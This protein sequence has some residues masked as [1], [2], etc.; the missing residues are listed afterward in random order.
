[1]SSEHLSDIWR[2]LPRTQTSLFWWKCARKGR[3]EGDNGRDASPAVCTLPMVP[4]GLLWSPVT[5]FALS[6]AMWKT[7]RLRRRLWRSTFEISVGAASFRY[8]NH[9]S[10]VWIEALSSMVFDSAQKQSDIGWT[11]PKSKVGRSSSKLI[12]GCSLWVIRVYLVL[13]LVKFSR[14][15][16]SPFKVINVWHQLSPKRKAKLFFSQ[17]S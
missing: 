15:G 4:C 13:A 1:M 2:S 16:R 3:R 6:S 10:Y 8:R 5:R 7:K 14:Q 11:Q 12:S 9:A 17:P